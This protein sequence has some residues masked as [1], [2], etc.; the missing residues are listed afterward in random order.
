MARQLRKIRRKTISQ[1]RGTEKVKELPP[2]VLI[3]DEV[4][5]AAPKSS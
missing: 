4:L 5:A 3:V 1:A 2:K